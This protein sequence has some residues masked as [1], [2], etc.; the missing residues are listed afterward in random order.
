VAA[1]PPPTPTINNLTACH[2]DPPTGGEESNFKYSINFNF[3][4]QYCSLLIKTALRKTGDLTGVKNSQVF[5]IF[6]IDSVP[7]SNQY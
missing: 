5:V 3:T 6:G 2:S 7:I 4:G 1:K